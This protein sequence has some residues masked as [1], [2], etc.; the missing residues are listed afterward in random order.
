MFDGK[1]MA[2]L[3][4]SGVFRACF[5]LLQKYGD[6]EDVSATWERCCSEA[7]EISRR[8]G[9]T[10]LAPMVNKMLG[11]TFDEIGRLYDAVHPE[12]QADPQSDKGQYRF[13]L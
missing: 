5:D 4:Y 2:C 9:Q 3:G 13:T 7:V 11:A 6:A 8:Y 1:Q 12:S 10:A